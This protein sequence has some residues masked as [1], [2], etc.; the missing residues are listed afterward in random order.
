M[1][2]NLDINIYFILRSQIT[3]TY[4]GQDHPQREDSRRP[5][6][7]WCG[8]RSWRPC[9]SWRPATWA[10]PWWA[11][12][13]PAPPWSPG[14]SCRAPTRQNSHLQSGMKYL[15]TYIQN[16]HRRFP[17]FLKFY[18]KLS[19][20]KTLSLW[21]SNISKISKNLPPLVFIYLK[22]LQCFLRL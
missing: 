4:T 15:Q 20:G 2:F 19:F 16:F 17:N 9:S 11:P 13:C 3:Y 7:A 8:H 1:A 10:A 14:T 12:P 5:G 21:N 18:L 6:A 22:I